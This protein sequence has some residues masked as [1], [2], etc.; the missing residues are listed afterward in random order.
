MNEKIYIQRR[1]FDEQTL[2]DEENDKSFVVALGS[3]LNGKSED[4]W[5]LEPT[6]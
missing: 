1:C 4:I 2:G 3:I 5:Y 6:A